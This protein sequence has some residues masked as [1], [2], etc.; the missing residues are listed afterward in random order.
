MYAVMMRKVKPDSNW[1]DGDTLMITP[2]YPITEND[3]FTF[4]PLKLLSVE[5]QNQIPASYKLYNNYPNPF[6]P[7]TTIKYDLQK[8]GKVVVEIFN[9]LGQKIKTLVNEDKVAGSY[10]ASWNGTTEKGLT[11]ASGIYFYRIKTENFSSTKKM[12]LMR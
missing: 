5:S 10:T 12:I 7:Q 2:Y 6:N 3:V 8:S 9:L 11:A 1:H 4:N